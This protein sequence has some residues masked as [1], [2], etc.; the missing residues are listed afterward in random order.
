MENKLEAL[1]W[2]N[3]KWSARS[4]CGSIWCSAYKQSWWWL[5]QTE[6]RDGSL[7]PHC[8]S[9]RMTEGTH[10]SRQPQLLALFQSPRWTA[11]TWLQSCLFVFSMDS[12][13]H[14]GTEALTYGGLRAWNP[15][16]LLQYGAR[17]FQRHRVYLPVS[18]A[19]D[20]IFAAA[21][22]SCILW[23]RS[24]GLRLELD[25]C[26]FIPPWFILLLLLVC[27]HVHMYDCYVPIVFS[28]HLPVLLHG[29]WNHF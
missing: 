21:P 20:C 25:L 18:C 16:S 6:T 2:H 13:I 9:P 1:I 29:S 7:F 3:G 11:S 28:A 22:F 27:V 26:T 12:V 17:L 15:A 14:W 24:S 5:Q 4:L 10:R 23:I 19:A 8:F